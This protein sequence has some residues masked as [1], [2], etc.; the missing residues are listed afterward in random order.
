MAQVGEIAQLGRDFAGQLVDAE[1]HPFQAGHVAQL[2][3][4]GPAQLIGPEG[5]VGHIVEAA[6]RGRDLPL[7]LIAPEGQ[8][9]Q[10]GET[11]DLGRN[12]AAQLILGEV[13]V[14]HA[15]VVGCHAVPLAE[16]FVA[17]PVLIVVPVVAARGVVEHDQG[18]SH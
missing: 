6:D 16:G 4:N 13:Q 11:A 7:Q 15:T 10:V 2:G 9:C 8:P 14:N 1:G 17:Q 3:G 18:V 5:Q 12:L